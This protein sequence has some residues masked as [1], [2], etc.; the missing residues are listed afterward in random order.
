VTRQPLRP[1]F[2]DPGVHACGALIKA[3]PFSMSR[4]AQAS[5]VP[6]SA[7]PARRAVHP[8]SRGTA[9]IAAHRGGEAVAFDARVPVARAVVVESSYMRRAIASLF[10]ILVVLITATALRAA[11]VSGTATDPSGAPVPAARVTLHNIATGAELSA[12]SDAEGRFRFPDLP[13]GIYRVTV[14]RDAFSEDSRTVAIA[15]PGERLEVSF[16]LRPG[17]L[18]TGVTVTAT[19]TERD[20]LQ[21]PLRTDSISRTAVLERAPT[22]TGDA[23][24]LA[25]NVVPVGSG[26]F[27]VRPRLRGLASTRLLV[28]V[29]GERLNNA[30]TATDRAGIEVGLIDP[31][32]IQSLEVVS[33]AG[34]VLY[35]TD[36]L[37]GTINILTVQPTFSDRLRVNYGFDGFFSSNETGRRGSATFGLS[38]RR[39]ALQLIAGME[40]FDN[41]R[42]GGDGQQEDVRDFYES[43]RIRQGDTVDDAFGFALRAFPEA[44]NA[45]YVRTTNEVFR[46]GADGSNLQLSGLVALT[47]NQTLRVKYIR[48]HM[49]NV[50]FPDFEPP[51][52][53]QRFW[54]PTNELDRISARYEARAVR[55][56]LPNVRVTAYYQ[57]QD[58]LLR[59]EFPVQFPV[60]TAGR[61]FPINVFR[62][63]IVSDTRQRVR[64]PGV[65][66]QA[67]F[68]PARNHLL[69]TGVTVYRD[70][71]R[72]SRFTRT[73]Q[74]LI[75]NVSMGARG[76]VA[77][78]LPSPVAV[79]APTTSNPVRVPNSAFRDV[80][81]F[82][83]DEWDINRYLRMVAGVRVDG[84][85]VTTEATPGYDVSSIV[86]GAQPPIPAAALPSAGGD[87]IT[88][89]ALTGDVGIVVR[90]TDSWSL[91]AHYGRSYRH[92]NLEELL[93]AGP[94]TVGAIAPNLLVGPETGHNVDVG[95]KTRTSRYAASLSYFNNRYDGFISTEVTAVVGNS[96]LY[97]AINFADVRIQGIEGDGELPL[98]LRRGTLSLFGGFAWTY[99]TVL[100][101]THPLT[102]ESLAGTPQDDIT[103]LKTMVGARF[104]DARDRFWV[105]YGTRIQPDVTRVA[106]TLL[107]QPFLIPQDLLA[108]EGFTVQ[109]LAWGVNL[110]R[111][112]GR[113][114]VTFAIENLGDTFYR[115]HF[116]FAPARGRS[117]TVG[118]HVRGN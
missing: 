92:A 21:V 88:R 104:T 81:V 87:Q 70:D 37:A 36:A 19:R 30:R 28:L 66:A 112:E 62:L 117:F 52:F 23:L 83:Q 94:A 74:S 99:G 61:F 9:C 48:R 67:T 43:G 105:E 34:S 5:W 2:A 78:V 6:C 96:P 69:T 18:T 84:Y 80:G 31:H 7:V 109:R 46:S 100:S 13:V 53:F 95:V 65:D 29:D 38:N 79:G 33:G 51:L 107:T 39:V 113:V 116:Q 44:F 108:L 91:L 106:T 8:P 111:D 56:W 114:G 72:D 24:V 20:P 57:D 97:Q 85:V 35:G 68:V 64:T 10:S 110:R 1:S 71:S 4:M 98:A 75:G 11:E 15:E 58:R 73:Q 41:Y 12:D 17:G 45:P 60:P 42:A 76:P 102:G 55:S 47:A 82:A 101:G 77:T 22:S 115:D 89:R 86:A 59:N 103:P 14:E 54:L 3:E 49:E 25:P 90:P 16:I 26:P 27:G 118:L 32:A 63:D 93:Y 50:G 40:R